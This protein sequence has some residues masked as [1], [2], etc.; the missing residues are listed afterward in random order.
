[1][2]MARHH[3]DLIMCLKITGP[4]VGRLCE[5]CEG[6]CPICDSYVKPMQIV[7]ICSDCSYGTHRERCIICGELGVSDAY[8]CRECIILEKDRDGCPKIINIGSAKTD[9]Y[10]ER[11]KYNFVNPIAK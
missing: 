3:P 6:K 11:K 10:F 1:M 9:L 8:Y 7:M 5:K 4:I 2:G